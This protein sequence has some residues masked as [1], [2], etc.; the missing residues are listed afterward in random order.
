[1]TPFG[2]GSDKNSERFSVS[3]VCT[4]TEAP[5]VE[6]KVEEKKE[7]P[8]QEQKS[9]SQ[10][11]TQQ[12]DNVA[13]AP[14]SEQ[15]DESRIDSIDTGKGDNFGVIVGIFSVMGILLI[16]LVVLLVYVYRK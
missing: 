5:K 6:V 11:E 16:V 8:K 13:P 7:E 12:Q 3:V 14:S 2:G 1:M 15:K 9:E 4:K 10:P